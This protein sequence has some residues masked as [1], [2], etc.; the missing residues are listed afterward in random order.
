MDATLQQISSYVAIGHSAKKQNG[1]GIGTNEFE[2]RSG[3]DVEINVNNLDDFLSRTLMTGR[4]LRTEKTGHV[5]VKD[6]VPKSWYH[7]HL[8]ITE[9]ENIL[10][11]KKN[12]KGSFIIR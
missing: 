9:A 11:D 2:Y 12:R 7:G 3:D 10:R 5:D 1:V 4:N 8:S 6:I